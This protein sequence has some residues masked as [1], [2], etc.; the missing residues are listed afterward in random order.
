MKVIKCFLCLFILVVR[1]IP[2]EAQ[3]VSGSS[4]SAIEEY[5]A[6]ELRR[7]M[8]QLSGKWLEI[9]PDS[10]PCNDPEFIVGQPASNRLIAEFEAKGMIRLP[11]TPAGEQG[12][13]LKTLERKGKSCLII[14]GQSEIGVL[15]GVYGLLEDHYHIGF[16]FSGDVLPDKKQAFTL[17]VIDEQKV[18]SMDIRGFLPWTNFPQSA[19]SYSW[20][21]WKY[22]IDQTAKMRM[23]FILVHNY[24]GELGHNEPFHNFE[25]RGYLSRVWMPTAGT[26]HKWSSPG[27]DVNQYLFGA[28]GFFDDYDFGSECALH[29]ENLTNEQVF[30]KGVSL[31]QKVIAYAHSRGVK[32]GLGLDI[33]LIMPDYKTTPDDPEVITARVDQ[34][35]TDYPDLD[36]LFCFQSENVGKDTA[37]FK[38]WK[39]IFDGFYNSIKKK[40]PQTRLAVSGW[41]LNPVSVGSLPADVI[42]APIAPYSAEFENGHIYGEREYWGCPWLERDIKSSQYYYPYGIHLSETIKSYRKRAPNMMGF[43]ALTWRLTDAIEPKMEYISK[44]PWDDRIVSSEQVYRRYAVLNYGPDAAG[45]ITA[46]INENEPFAS[47]FG[48]CE[49]TRAFLPD[50]AGKTEFAK[51][52]EQLSVIDRLIKNAVSPSARFRLNLLRC[53]IAAARDHIRLNGDFENYTWNHLP[54]AMRSW[55]ENFM[56]RVTDIST[57]GNIVSI[58]NRFV[59]NN[60]LAKEKEFREQQTIKAPSCVQAKGTKKGAVITWKNEESGAAGFYIYRDDRQIGKAPATQTS[61]TD[62]YHGACQYSV[63]AVH[64]EG[65]ESPKSVPYFCFA[66]NADDKAPQINVISSAVS[67]PQGQPLS[68]KISLL[69]N[70]NDEDL[71]AVFYYR[72][73]GTSKWMALPMIRKVKSTFTVYLPGEFITEEGLEYYFKAS[74]DSN[75]SVFPVT[76]PQMNLSLVTYRTPGSAPLPPRRVSVAANRIQWDK[77][78]GDVFQYRIYR[79]SF[80]DFKPGW[81]NLV[82]YVSK[83]TNS[84]TDNP[85]DFDG[86]KMSGKRYYRITAVGFYD[87]E[88]QPSD[89]VII[90]YSN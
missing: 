73:P 85:E 83:E 10:L 67:H 89:I 65:N 63:S 80:K 41:G 24:N 47:D 50:S 27:W 71:S 40:S 74:D 88:S 39:R 68:M 38:I 64:A 19:T 11:D 34:I 1:F 37:F 54:G 90:D 82:T 75:V 53:R 49:P 76:A 13:I 36:Y 2:A 8:Y 20:N 5:A 55:T 72:K 28:S 12:Y 59:R 62:L 51:A 3:I 87:H 31:F 4:G 57:L 6:K 48:E 44:A 45:E 22:I 16:Y 58:Q 7:Y 32:I 25:H 33:N 69:D 56:N 15:Y 79:S 35:V 18:P 29:N 30:R 78:D 84:Y 52:Q 86:R 9:I 60:Y 61:F 66:G 17:P 21:D 81:N 77:S 46:I 42:C 43:F 23:N 14:A 26:G 70:R